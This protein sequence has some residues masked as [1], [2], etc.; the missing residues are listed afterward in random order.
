[1][2]FKSFLESLR[3]ISISHQEKYTFSTEAL[4]I[5]QLSQPINNEIRERFYDYAKQNDFIEKFKGIIKGEISNFTEIKP[6][7][8]FQYKSSSFVEDHWNLFSIAKRIKSSYKRVIFF[9]IGG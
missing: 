5:E 2:K 7:T 9:G 1:M 8:H 6:A 4:S 3:S